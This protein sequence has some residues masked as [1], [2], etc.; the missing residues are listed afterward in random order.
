MPI[1]PI[2]APATGTGHRRSTARRAVRWFVVPALTYLCGFV[3]LTWPWAT[4]VASGFF[5]DD[6]DGYQMVWNL[7]WVDLA[8]RA[9]RSPWFTTILHAP[10]GT[11][12]LGHSLTPFNGL[13]AMAGTAL[14]LPLVVAHNGV[15]AFSFVAAGTTTFWLAVDQAGS[16]AGS[17]LAGFAFTFGGYHLEHAQGHLELVAVEWLPLFLLV[18]GRLLRRPSATAGM[19]AAGVLWLVLLCDYY[20]FF[21][22]V[23]TG[24]AMLAWH[25]ARG[26]GGRSVNWSLFRGIGPFVALALALCGPIVLPLLQLDLH[27]AHDPAMNSADLLA[28]IVPGSHSWARSLT[29]GY[30]SRLPGDANETSV[31]FGLS[32]L[33]LAGIGTASGTGARRWF[34]VA[35]GVAFWVLALGPSLQ[36]G[37]HTWLPNCMPYAGLQRAFP[38]LRIAGM[39]VRMMVMASIAASVLAAD[40]V[41]VLVRGGPAGRAVTVTL[42]AVMTVELWP[43]ALPI[44]PV[45]VP[46]WVTALRDLPA[47][48]AMIDLTNTGTGQALYYQTVHRRP[49]ASGYISRV[50][51][52]VMR[53]DERIAR[54]VAA[55]RWQAVRYEFGFRYLVAS[56]GGPRPGRGVVYDGPD[57]RIIDLDAIVR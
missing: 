7:W 51:V 56:A 52:D 5:C 55:G 50:P 45:S 19:L 11:T 6:G 30:W 29:R 43:S 3:L 18:W 14:G 27:G 26:H 2:D 32:V 34:W 24:T 53:A 35:V 47:L 44:A 25:L 23:A 16:Y 20:Y 22:A 31:F 28:A 9:G 4:H 21:F 37:G 10:G 38:P 1:P 42:A 57:R 8:L 49:M 36:V 15:V 48:G 33:A 41:A 17:L 13:L 54:A 12:L 39:P 40:G 46:A